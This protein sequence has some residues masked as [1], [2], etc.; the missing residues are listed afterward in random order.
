MTLQDLTE[1][2]LACIADL[3]RS[4]RLRRIKAISKIDKPQPQHSMEKEALTKLQQKL[5]A[6]HLAAVNKANIEL[7]QAIEQPIDK[8]IAATN[9][10]QWDKLAAQARSEIP[11]SEVLPE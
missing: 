9:G 11:T 4:Y 2:E 10:A 6:I 3:F 5:D 1:H 7:S 8:A